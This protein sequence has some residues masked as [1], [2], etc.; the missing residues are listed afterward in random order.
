MVIP[1]LR[2]IAFIPAA[3]DLHPSA[4]IARV[5]TVAQVVAEKIEKRQNDQLYEAGKS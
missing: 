2:S 5:R 4:N 3:T 1:R